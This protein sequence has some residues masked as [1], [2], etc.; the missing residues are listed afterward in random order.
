MWSI[1]PISKTKHSH[2]G[3]RSM[4]R[5]KSPEY[6]QTTKVAI[7]IERPLIEGSFEH[8]FNDLIDA[9][10]SRRWTHCIATI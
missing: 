4:P 5:Y 8:A 1:G 7:N 2:K 6:G 10:A 9:L 3:A